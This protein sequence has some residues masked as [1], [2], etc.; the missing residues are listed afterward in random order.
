LFVFTDWLKKIP[1]PVDH[2]GVRTYTLVPEPAA[3]S[4]QD[5]EPIQPRQAPAPIATTES[6]GEFEM[7]LG[8]RQAASLTFVALVVMAVCSGGSYLIGRYAAPP[9]A[10]PRTQAEVPD[11][12]PIPLPV[13]E[14]L[15]PPE[16]PL[17]DVPLKGPVYIQLGAVDKGVAT[18]LANGARKI[19]FAAFVT[20]G[21][22]ANVFRVLVGP[23]KN[24]T[25]YDTAVAKFK[26]IGL[27]NFSRRY[28]EN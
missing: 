12:P 2:T 6:D 27:D 22:N 7:V 20:P 19:G 21:A 26:E 4:L 15:P 24:A 25:D 16:A 18:L 28:Q 3:A 11:P 9:A 8:K 23:F 14:V 5:S 1:T 13:A 10:N 17:F